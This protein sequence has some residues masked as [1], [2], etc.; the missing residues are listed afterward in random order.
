LARSRRFVA[1]DL[2]ASNG[3]VVAGDW[4]GARFHVEEIHRFDNEPV[5]EAGHLHWDAAALWTEIKRGL[6]RCADGAAGTA[7][8]GVGIDTWGVDYALLNRE[9]ELLGNPFHYRDRRTDG[10][11][12][13]AFERVPRA[14]IYRATGIQPMQ[15]NTLFQLFSMIRDRDPQLVAAATLLPLPNLFSYWLCGNQAAEYT[16]ATTTQCL[17]VRN[18]RWAVDLMKEFDIPTDIFPPLVESGTVLGTLPGRLA[19]EVGMHATTPVVAVGSHDTASAVAAIPGLDARSAFISSGTWSLMGVLVGEPVISD[20]ALAGGFTNEGGVGGTIRLLRNIPGLWLVQECRRHW[21]QD[22]ASYS[23]AEL[24]EL[25]ERTEPLRCVVD[26]ADPALL[27]PPDMPAAIRA[28]CRRSGAEVPHSAG[29]VIRC[30][31]ESVALSYR[32][33]I[34]DLQTL[35]GHRL[36]A[37]WI[38]GGG[39]RNA[40]LCQLTA[41]ACALPVVAGP[42]EATALG[43]LMVQAVA[44]GEIDDLDAGRA[45]IAES[46]TQQTYEPRSCEAWEEA[47]ARFRR[48]APNPA[49]E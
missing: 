31:L 33:T 5:H 13:L 28:A 49:K 41:D 45:A 43:N 6:A 46:T 18:H 21:E 34:D 26:P 30:C 42:A 20:F 15:I 47:L 3:R 25:A 38:V 24:I 44:A 7:V 19:A 29:A 39:S 9:G 16:H 23:W 10:A 11:M 22:G 4:D 2:G 40:L 48:I 32:A 14:A 17:D 12:E 8:S 1:V 27:N 35:I 36:E 37:I